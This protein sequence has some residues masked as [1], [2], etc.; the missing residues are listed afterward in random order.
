MATRSDVAEFVKIHLAVRL[1]RA[2]IA[3]PADDLSLTNTGII[4]SFGLLELVSAAE[5]RFGI[6]VN[7]DAIDIDE[8]TTF[9][10][11]VD[12]VSKAL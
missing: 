7:V 3:Q 10:G 9:G 2:G 5:A 1:K 6:E 4:D 11:F 8:L 12:A